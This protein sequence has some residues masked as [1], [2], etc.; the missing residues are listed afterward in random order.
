M[1]THAVNKKGGGKK[2]YLCGPA[3]SRVLVQ[4]TSRVL[5]ILSFSM[6]LN[7][8]SI[9]IELLNS[10]SEKP[11]NRLLVSTSQEPGKNCLQ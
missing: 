11:G 4:V 1:C 9:R 6:I 7:K 10:S 8:I 3:L 5:S 2:Q